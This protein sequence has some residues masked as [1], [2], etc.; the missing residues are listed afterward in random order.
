VASPASNVHARVYLMLLFLI[1]YAIIQFNAKPFKFRQNN[2]VDLSFHV[3]LITLLIV[4]TSFIDYDD[5][6]RR[7]H[8]YWNNLYAD[9]ILT[10][11]GF[12][13][14]AA[15]LSFIH[16]LWSTWQHRGNL[17]GKRAQY[18]WLFRD[19]AVSML[20]LPD[21]KLLTRISSL[22]DYDL[23][24]LRGATE[25]MITVLFGAQ[26]RSRTLQQRLL[27]HDPFRMWDYKDM[28]LNAWEEVVTGAFHERVHTS[29]KV[30][31]WLTKLVLA[32]TANVGT[33]SQC[34][35]DFVSER[36]ASN[37][38]LGS[39]GST[40]MSGAS[41]KKTFDGTPS[42]RSTGSADSSVFGHL[43]SDDLSPTRLTKSLASGIGEVVLMSVPEHIE[44]L[45]TAL[46]L[47]INDSIDEEIFSSKVSKLVPDIPFDDIDVIFGVLDAQ[48]TGE[49]T[50]REIR[51][52]LNALLPKE[53]LTE[54][55]MED[56]IMIEKAKDDD[57]DGANRLARVVQELSMSAT[58]SKTVAQWRSQRSCH[59]HR[60]NCSQSPRQSPTSTAHHIDFNKELSSPGPVSEHSD[61]SSSG[62]VFPV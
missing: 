15:L 8:E 44:H 12:C 52:T 6:S 21:Q 39:V 16:W 37:K 30:R 61:S 33:Q 50:K 60:T 7:E 10:F 17:E 25:T 41:S 55:S 42:K 47:D 46:G 26:V 29:Y 23:Q 34:V 48:C 40:K 2:R 3:F 58:P 5:L 43:G 18:A 31:A 36:T 4:A 62:E 57:L 35:T 54:L 53:L 45:V 14:V 32:A 24:T 38:N 49:I 11:L 20:M 22:S 1:P 51:V 56:I 19:C 9:L 27:P 13:V 28:H 59:S